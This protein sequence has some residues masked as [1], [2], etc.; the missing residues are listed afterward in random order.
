M[1]LALSLLA[2][3]CS[4]V[5]WP[6]SATPELPDRPLRLRVHV[7]GAYAAEP[8][9]THAQL[10]QIVHD[11]DAVFAST[12]GVHLVI[13]EIVDGWKV[14]GTETAAAL[15]ALSDED[16]GAD[17]DVVVGMLGG[18][19]R[20]PNGCLGMATVGG[21]VMVVRGGESERASAHATAVLAFLHELGHVLGAPHDDEPG[22]IMNAR[23]SPPV[24]T[25]GNASAQLVRA[26][27]AR[28]GIA[29]DPE[30]LPGGLRTA[31]VPV[32]SVSDADRPTLDRALDAEGHGDSEGAWQVGA[33]LFATYPDVVAVQDLRCRLARARGLA[34]SDVRAECAPLMRLM[35]VGR[36]PAE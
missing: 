3:A 33:P 25:Y 17:V 10:R 22:S 15:R 16:P 12:L 35:T 21:K 34:W 24:G 8:I 1:L 19:T 28:L 13:A 4:P 11:A 2:L 36:Y 29:A 5:A 27:L 30:G 32:K 23:G 7:S 14:D 20:D 9:G 26:G 6:A 18:G 31:A